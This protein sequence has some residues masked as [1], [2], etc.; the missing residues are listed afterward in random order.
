MKI[1]TPNAKYTFEIHDDIVD[2]IDRK[3]SPLVIKETWVENVY[4]VNEGDFHASNI[5]VDIGANIGAMSIYVA[6]FNE[7]REPDKKIKIF[8]YEPEPHNLQSLDTNIRN[9]E[10]IG[11]IKVHSKAVYPSTPVQITHSGGGSSVFNRDGKDLPFTEVE[12]VTLEKVFS[13]NNIQECDVLKMDIEGAEYHN[14]L[15]S[16]DE[17]LKRIR[18]ITLEFHPIDDITFGEFITKLAHIFNIHIIGK[19]S[20]GGQIYGR[21]Y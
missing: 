12:A 2:D 15:G 4:Q 1:L 14:I 7:N 9:N 21:R 3:T 17:T 18:Y 20:G 19:P 11:Q 5:F 10:V 13:E 8:A 16:S 6:S